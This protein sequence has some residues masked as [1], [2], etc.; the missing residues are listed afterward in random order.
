MFAIEFMKNKE[1]IVPFLFGIE[2]NPIHYSWIFYKYM[3]FA[4]KNGYPIIADEAYFVNPSVY[5]KQNEFSFQNIVDGYNVLYEFKKPTDKDMKKVIQF[6]ITKEE[7]EKVLS[8]FEDKEKAI[9]HILQSRDEKFEDM[10]LS[11]LR[12][13]EE[14]YGKIVA[15]LSWTYFPSLEFCCQQLGIQLITLEQ[16]T[17]RPKGYRFKFGYFQFYN[18]YDSVRMDADYQTFLQEFQDS[19]QY[20]NR[21]ELLALFLADDQLKWI[22]HLDDQSEY[23]FGLSIGPDYDPLASAFCHMPVLNVLNELKEN[24]QVHQVLTR[25][26][27]MQKGI[28][29]ELEIF[30]QDHSS[31]S[32][33]WILKC[34]RIISIGSNVAFEAMLLGK[35]SYVLGDNF[36]YHYGSITELNQYEEKIADLKYINY[37]VFGYYVPYSLMFDR[38][39]ILW[40]LTNPSV[41]EI[42]H[43]HLDY[44]MKEFGLSKKLFDMTFS[45]RLRTI[46]E[47]HPALKKKEITAFVTHH[48]HNLEE[49]IQQLH[50]ELSQQKTYYESRLAEVVANYEKEMNEQTEKYNQIIN[51]KSWKVTKPLRFVTNHLAKSFKK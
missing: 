7:K 29:K 23:D 30:P 39:Y 22:N 18:K 2:K 45:Q 25:V 43:Y 15:V 26:H 47:T 10:I 40:R 24:F 5:E 46:L 27:P 8:G 35:T 50:C 51:S 11:K 6:P 3:D 38:D 16:T 9:I 28:R 36:P 41:I 19:N 4:L 31:S 34:R 42:Y 13:I 14:K 32:L 20:F 21:K 44:V 12:T 49:E 17:F 48:N 33:E 37:I 1:N